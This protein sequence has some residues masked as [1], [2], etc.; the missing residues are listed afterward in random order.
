MPP[1][2]TVCRRPSNRGAFFVRAL[3]VCTLHLY[4]QPISGNISNS[5]SE[6]GFSY[7]A[8]HSLICGIDA[9]KKPNPLRVGH[10]GH[11]RDDGVHHLFGAIRGCC[12]GAPSQRPNRGIRLE[13]RRH[14]P[15]VQPPVDSLWAGE[16]LC[17]MARGPIRGSLVPAA[18]SLAIHRR[19]VADRNHE[20]PV[21]ILPLLRRGPGSVHDHLYRAD[22]VRRHPVVQETLGS[23][24]GG[25]MV[26]SGNWRNCVSCS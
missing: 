2:G 20:Q 5:A 10:R 17:G 26:V 14:Q 24:H 16:P 7:N 13:L 19:H 1:H 18:R 4:Q 22:G 21:A 15:C 25:R 12:L 11:R 9:P 8:T 6:N 23:R 3:F